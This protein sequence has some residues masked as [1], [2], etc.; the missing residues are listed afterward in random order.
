MKLWNIDGDD[1]ADN[2][3]DRNC[4]RYKEAGYDFNSR[5]AK[6]TKKTKKTKKQ[7]HKQTNKQRDETDPRKII[8]RST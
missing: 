5:I 7:K 3:K 2:D 1:A 6:K 8:W 4:H